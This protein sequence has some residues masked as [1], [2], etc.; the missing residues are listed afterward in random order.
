MDVA[1]LP[2]QVVPQLW[3]AYKKTKE[4]KD[5][6]IKVIP[7]HH[8]L[9][10]TQ[11][12]HELR[13]IY[14]KFVN[15]LDKDKNQ[16]VELEHR[17]VGDWLNEWK[18]MHTLLFKHILKDRGGWRKINVRF[19]SPG[20]EE[21][22][23]IPN[24]WNVGKEIGF[25]AKTI[26]EKLKQKHSSMEDIFRTLA[27]IHYQFIRIHPF[28]DGNGRIARAITDQLALYFG[29]PVAMGGYPRHD[30]KRRFAYHKAIRDCA[31]DPECKELSLWIKSYIDKQLELIA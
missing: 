1:L 21:I 4:Y 22:Y 13:T 14:E 30:L 23:H 19:G 12:K 31:D 26:Q 6:Q 28:A 7:P 9:V 29:L 8:K 25:L 24:H 15:S 10:E 17:N 11:E 20:D 3:A 2:D 16:K 5:G 27:I 18:T